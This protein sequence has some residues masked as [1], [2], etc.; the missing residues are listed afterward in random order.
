M[1]DQTRLRRLR[2]QLAA[3]HA[4][5]VAADQQPRPD[6]DHLRV[7]A[8]NGIAAGLQTAIFFVDHHL[9][10]AG[11]AARTTADNSATSG[12]AADNLLRD[13]IAESLAGHAGSKAFLA[14]GREWDHARAAWYA[15]AD[16]V[17][18]VRD[19]EMERLHAEL[20]RY[21]EAESADA[22][23]GSYAGRA[24]Q[25]EAAIARV[26]EYLERHAHQV[27]VTPIDLLALLNAPA[28]SG[29]AATQATVA[30]SYPRT[31]PNNPKGGFG[32]PLGSRT[33]MSRFLDAI[34]HT[35]PGYNPTPEP[36]PAPDGLRERLRTVLGRFIDPDDDCMPAL[37][38]DGHGFTWIPT[39]SVLDELEAA[40]AHRTGKRAGE[41][42]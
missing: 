33:R 11:E 26:R 15:H 30:G 5:A 22:A 1:T 8:P 23:A 17:L 32:Q 19:R 14:D 28:P 18:A 10:E 42:P 16:A 2:A 41:A 21:T 9:R 29:P 27:A 24:E 31:T 6:L 35:G 4:K 13:Q 25:A 34:T 40:V 3:E 36:E 20:R 7:T 38:D 37:S 12:D 39:D